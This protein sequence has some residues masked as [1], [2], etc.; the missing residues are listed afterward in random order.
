MLLDAGADYS[1]P[2]NEGNTPLDVA[3]MGGACDTFCSKMDQVS[4]TSQA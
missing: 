3:K 4:E 2:D 1:I